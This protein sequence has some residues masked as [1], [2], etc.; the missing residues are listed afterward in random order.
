MFELM[1]LGREGIES[2]VMDTGQN[3]L[4]TLHTRGDIEMFDVSGTNFISRGKYSRIKSDLIARGFGGNAPDYAHA[5]VVA[6]ST[7]G[8]HESRRACLV[9]MTT[10]GKL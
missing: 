1:R 10:N 6:L 7:I 3:R 4:F 9:A 2:L 5:K 8:A